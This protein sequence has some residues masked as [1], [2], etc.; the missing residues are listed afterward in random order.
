[1][2]VSIQSEP[3]WFFQATERFHRDIAILNFYYDTP[4]ITGITLE[5]RTSIFDM[6]SAIGGTLGSNS[7]NSIEFKCR[8]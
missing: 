6:I 7:D 1:M 8:H 4:I 3:R 5:L 2:L